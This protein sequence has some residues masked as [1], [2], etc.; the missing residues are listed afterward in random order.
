MK[1]QHIELNQADEKQ[2]EALLS[3]GS[4]R[5][6]VYK[7]AL[8]LLELHRGKTIVEVARLLQVSYPTAHSW[9]RKY[10]QEGLAFLQDKARSGRPVLY[11]GLAQ[12]RVVALAC[13]EAPEGRSQWTLR[14]LADKAVELGLVADISY[15]E[16]GRILK[17][18]NTNLTS[19][20]SGASGS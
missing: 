19:S 5:A 6:Q 17:K 13:S 4:L 8:A 12:A 20:A 3:K 1:K 11:D 15:V 9:V 14:L 10:R 2:I 18:T 16:V 7:R